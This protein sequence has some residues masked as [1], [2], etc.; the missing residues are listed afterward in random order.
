MNLEESYKAVGVLDSSL[1]Q[2]QRVEHPLIAT[3]ITDE[4]V[5]QQ[6][7]SSFDKIASCTREDAV[8]KARFRILAACNDVP[9]MVKSFN[10]KT[11]FSG[12]AQEAKEGQ[13]I[14][15][16]TQF[17]VEDS[18]SGAGKNKVNTLLLFSHAGHGHDFFQGIT[19]EEVQSGKKLKQV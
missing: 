3:M 11:W 13:N 15:Y 16:Q 10:N 17:Y 7:I 19:P 6:R 2:A 9:S 14:I 1:W 18:S 4:K 12:R 5:R 8:F